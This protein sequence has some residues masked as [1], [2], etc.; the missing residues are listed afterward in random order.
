[1]KRPFTAGTPISAR[2]FFWH[3]ANGCAEISSLQFFSHHQVWQDSADVG[4][5]VRSERTGD[6]ITFVQTRTEMADDCDAQNDDIAA[7]HYASIDSRT[8]RID[9]TKNALTLTLFND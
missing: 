9:R 2:A 5:T 7:W 3:Q 1:M 4:L 6:L 8:G